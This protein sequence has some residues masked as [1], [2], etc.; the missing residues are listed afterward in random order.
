[1]PLGAFPLLAAFI[2]H[3]FS[4]CVPSS[5]EP[6]DSEASSGADIS[7]IATRKSGAS[8]YGTEKAS[9]VSCDMVENELDELGRSEADTLLGTAFCDGAL[10]MALDSGNTRV[11]RASSCAV[12][13]HVRGFSSP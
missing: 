6:C 8:A 1:M 12:W 9:E 4:S 5:S 13:F 11:T 2:S 7:C 10:L 3:F